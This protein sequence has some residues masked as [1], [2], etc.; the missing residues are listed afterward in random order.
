MQ[1]YLSLQ[2]IVTLQYNTC[3]IVLQFQKQFYRRVIKLK[4][5]LKLKGFVA[6]KLTS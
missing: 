5:G 6:L 4:K 1:Y 3:F 2:F